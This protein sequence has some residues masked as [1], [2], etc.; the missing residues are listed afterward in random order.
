MA[1]YIISKLN[2][3]IKFILLNQSF[4]ISH[5]SDAIIVIRIIIHCECYMKTSATSSMM[6]ST[7]AVVLT[8]TVHFNVASLA[9]S[10]KYFKKKRNLNILFFYHLCKIR[11]SIFPRRSTIHVSREERRRKKECW[12]F[13]VT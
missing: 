6:M 4:V 12:C 9:L 1:R 5:K 13:I 10:L 7:R 8:Y 2:F 3:T 11:S